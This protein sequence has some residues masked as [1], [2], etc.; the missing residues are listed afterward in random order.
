M[1]NKLVNPAHTCS[2]QRLDSGN[3]LTSCGAPQYTLSAQFCQNTDPMFATWGFLNQCKV[4]DP[5]ISEQEREQMC[6][7][8]KRAKRDNKDVMCVFSYTHNSFDEY[9]L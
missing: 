4:D 3:L 8:E 5:Y 1:R 7:E 6:C 2:R 9:E